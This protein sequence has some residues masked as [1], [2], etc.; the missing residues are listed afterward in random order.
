MK[1]HHFTHVGAGTARQRNLYPV[2][3]RCWPD[4]ENGSVAA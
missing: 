4:L 3:A 1:L 2:L